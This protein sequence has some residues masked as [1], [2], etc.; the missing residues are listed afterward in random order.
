MKKSKKTIIIA[1]VLC[2][3]ICIGVLVTK[4]LQKSEPS[5]GIAEGSSQISRIPADKFSYKYENSKFRFSKMF[6]YSGMYVE[7]G[8]DEPE[9]GIAAIRIKNNTGEPCRY[10]EIKVMTDDGDFEFVF[11]TLMNGE[12]VTVLEKNKRK[13]NEKAKVN[14][15]SIEKKSG[16]EEIPDLF[17]NIFELTVNDKVINIKNVS[18]EDIAGTVYVY[19][20]NIDENGLLGGITYR[21]AFDSLKAGELKQASSKHLS[22]E[23][24]IMEF[25][26]YEH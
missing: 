5:A 15:I 2:V 4:C 10:A 1:V 20:K 12:S 24:S 6:S 16:F 17:E 18:D 13:Y 9:T 25:I 23:N 3:C 8:T 19:Y 7:D 22:K 26:T 14:S 21:V 11:T